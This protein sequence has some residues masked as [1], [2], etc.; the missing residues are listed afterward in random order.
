LEFLRKTYLL[1]TSLALI[2]VGFITL[3]AGMLSVGPIL[4]VAGYC[5]G[6]P[7]FIWRAFQKSVGE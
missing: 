4:L 7:L 2:L 1:W 3:E 6:M 5:I